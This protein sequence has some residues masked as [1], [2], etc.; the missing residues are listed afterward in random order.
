MKQMKDRHVLG[1]ISRVAGTRKWYIGLL[2]LLQVLLGFSGVFYALLLREIIDA[3]V[4]GD[5]GAF[6]QNAILFIGLVIIQIAMRALNR[7]YLEYTKVRLQ[8]RFKKR[9]FSALMSKNYESVNAVHT[10][11]WLNRLTSD[12]AIVADGLVQILPGLSG[13]TVKLVA[14]LTMLLV[15]EKKFAYFIIPGGI[16]L[17][18]FTSGFRKVLKGMHKKIQESDGKMRILF[19][20]YLESLLV[21]RSYGMEDMANEEAAEKMGHYKRAVLKRSHFSNMCNIGLGVV[22]HGAYVSGAIYCGYGILTQTMSYGTFTA[23]LQLISQVQSPF[24]NITGFLP[25]YYSMIA[26]AERLMEIEQLPEKETTEVLEREYVHDRYHSDLKA[27]GLAEVGF[28]YQA[29]VQQ[30]AGEI[31]AKS[32]ETEVLKSI[33]LEI[34]KGDYVAFT[35]PSGCGKSTTLKIFL[36][37]YPVEAGERYLQFGSERVP[38]D[39]RWQ[40]LFAYVPQSNHLMSGTVREIVAFSDKCEMHDEARMQN[41]LEIACAKE[42]VDELEFGVDTEL[43]ERGSGLSEGQMQRL[44]I[45]RAIFSK[46]PILM[47]DESTSALDEETERKLLSN[48]RSMTDKTVLI[49]THRPAVLEICDKVVN[50][51]ETGIEIFRK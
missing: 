4:Q 11:E 8:N 48:L 28:T 26:S 2:T 44:A 16:L 22:M 1:W 38:L 6:T 45:A 21:V 32:Y 42:F 19:Q 46:N 17:L 51:E 25:R 37:L 34:Q 43:G 24:A 9:I 50:F 27:I 47:M 14:A 10:G 15:L 29:P 7:F 35:G 3:A 40:K 36:G 30:P 18:L 33:D 5:K 49:V 31:G 23:V 41:A 39:S 20:E 12:S 13:M